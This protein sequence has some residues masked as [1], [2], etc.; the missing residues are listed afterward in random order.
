[1]EKIREK[2]CLS[3]LL[4]FG[5]CIQLKSCTPAVEGRDTLSLGASISGNQ[6]IVSKNSTFELGFFNPSGTNNWYIGIWYAN[7][8][9]KTYVW[10]ANRETPGKNKAGVLNLSEGGDLGLFD[11]TGASLWS[12]NVTKKVYQAV[13]LD[14]GNFV[15]FGDA[16]KSEMVWQSFDYPTDTW[17][18]GMRF[19]GQQ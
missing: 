8:T 14:S 11:A 12:V 15:M 19:G 16:N 18:P 6:T 4:L 17:L 9:E 10:V 1:M 3:L 5:V 7:L 13:I 2:F